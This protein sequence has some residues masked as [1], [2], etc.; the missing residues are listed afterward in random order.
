VPKVGSKEFSYTKAGRK[1]AKKEAART[2]KPM[3]KAK[4]KPA[5]KKRR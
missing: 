3:Q 4:G 5:M 1:A 2:G